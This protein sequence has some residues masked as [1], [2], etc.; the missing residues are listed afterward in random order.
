VP[1]VNR[2]YFQQAVLLCLLRALTA[3]NELLFWW[4]HLSPELQLWHMVL[5]DEARLVPCDSHLAMGNVG[6]A[7]LVEY[8][9][10]WNSPSVQRFLPLQKLVGHFNHTACGYPRFTLVS[11]T[12][13][14]RHLPESWSRFPRWQSWEHTQGHYNCIVMEIFMPWWQQVTPHR[15]LVV[16]ICRTMVVIP[17]R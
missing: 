14:I 2:L 16:R 15:C 4:F 5:R 8:N 1:E 10:N 13:C 17:V 6:N 7:A 11:E 3:K 9:N 12:D